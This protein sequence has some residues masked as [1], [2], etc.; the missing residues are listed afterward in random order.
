MKRKDIKRLHVNQG[1]MAM[2]AN[3]CLHSGNT[4]E[5]DEY[6]LR[7]FAY[8]MSH[9]GDLPKNEVMLYD[10][11][12]NTEDALINSLTAI[13]PYMAHRFFWAL[14]KVN[15]FSNF[16]SWTTFDISKCS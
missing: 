10:W 9:D 5:S 2:C 16:C 7:L 3:T 12:D 11:T 13:G 4:N 14:F 15:N 1:K 8:L 6:R